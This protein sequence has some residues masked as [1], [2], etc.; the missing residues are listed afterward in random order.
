MLEVFGE[1]F[2]SSACNASSF[3]NNEVFCVQVLHLERNVTLCSWNLLFEVR[4]SLAF[5][6]FFFVF[7]FLFILSSFVFVMVSLLSDRIPSA[8]DETGA[9]STC[10]ASVR[11]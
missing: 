11:V 6:R 3:A 4:G 9:V 10:S 5:V 8:Q 2:P 1:A 7:C